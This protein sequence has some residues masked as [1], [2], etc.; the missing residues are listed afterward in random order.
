M[1]VVAAR[2]GAV[3]HRRVDVG[4][5]AEGFVAGGAEVRRLRGELEG[6]LPLLRVRVGRGLVAGVA[7]LRGGVDALALEQVLVAL[8]GRAGIPGRGEAA[9]DQKGSEAGREGRAARARHSAAPAG[10]RRRRRANAPIPRNAIS[11]RAIAARILT[12]FELP[13]P[14]EWSPVASTKLTPR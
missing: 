3:L 11:T 6:L 9:G 12:R 1:R 14:Y 10:T 13:N 5:L 2:A 8:R 7:R 4:L